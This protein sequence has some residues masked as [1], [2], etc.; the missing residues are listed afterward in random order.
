MSRDSEVHSTVHDNTF[1][2]PSKLASVGQ[3]ETGACLTRTT[4]TL[5]TR[6]SMSSRAGNLEEVVAGCR[7]TLCLSDQI[8]NHELR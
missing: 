8:G 6:F 1:E 2:Y 7:C 4:W 3:H 5:L